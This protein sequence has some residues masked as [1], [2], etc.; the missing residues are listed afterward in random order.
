MNGLRLLTSA[1][2]VATLL[3]CEQ[4]P[5][6]TT[7]DTINEAGFF[8]KFSPSAGEI[9][10]PNNLL[11]SGSVDGTL[12]IP[13]TSLTG[14]ELAVATALNSMDGFSTVA[15]ISAGFSS[16]IDSATLVAGT[17]VR[18]F[19]VTITGPIVTSIDAELSASDFSVSLSTVDGADVT[20]PDLG[21]NKLVIT[22][23]KP[24]KP[25][26][27]YVALLTNGIK[28][29]QGNNAAADTIY[30]FTKS[31][32]TLTTTS[33]VAATSLAEVKYSALLS[34]ADTDGNGTI[35]AGA[36]T[37]AALFSVNSL[38]GLRQVTN[39]TEA[40][41]VASASPAITSA[42]II[43][44][45][46]FNTQ[47]T[48]IS[49]GGSV[50]TDARANVPADPAH[51]INS[52]ATTTTTIVGG[53]GYADIHVGTIDVPYYQAA[54]DDAELS[55]AGPAQGYWENSDGA[56]SF[57]T[58]A[59]RIPVA[60]STQ[61]IPLLL[62]IPNATAPACVG[63]VVGCKGAGWPVV[64]F[65]HGIT[66]DR[67]SLLA[68]ADSLA[69]RGIAAVAIDMPLHGLFANDVAG[70]HAA[71]AGL[72]NATER[73]FEVDYVDNETGLPP[74]GDGAD[75]SGANFV[76]LSYLMTTRGNLNQAIADLFVVKQSLL[77]SGTGTGMDYSG[78]TNGDFDPA[79]IY[80][81]GHSLGA[82]VGA[83]F[84]AIES[85]NMGTDIKDAV[86]AMPGGGIAKLL[87]GSSTFGPVISAGLAA[88]GV[89]KGTAEFE[90]FL[91]ASQMM[92]DEGDPINYATTLAASLEGILM[93]EVVGDGVDN[94][95]DLVIPNSVADANDTTGTVPAV[96]SGTEPLITLMNLDH[97]N[98]D[99]STA[100]L[101]AV[102]KYT[103]GDHGSL[104]DPTASA[105]ATTEMQTQ[106]AQFLIIDGGF[107]DVTDDAVLEAPPAP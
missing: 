65:Q 27:S 107:L 86:L 49:P 74:G 3:G 41:I 30:A 28:G 19:E 77:N 21:A 47:S 50:L 80:F 100:N 15:P 51:N 43:L 39:V 90:S 78:D 33:P 36:E 55:I 60:Q 88:N 17:T 18:V 105:A 101:H 40:T 45:W 56:G 106:A 35:D 2:I 24:L 76:N 93:F 34:T 9:P 75:T 62:S 44:S 11:F 84:V 31:T 12:N 14:G 63:D 32:A 95:S 25:S 72:P 58:P 68:I 102:V 99:T 69:A 46:S 29:L 5:D 89:T 4:T 8:A 81:V 37:T 98:V 70:I 91:S 53:A 67:T 59:N 52:T 38:E 92:V 7:Q 79:K 64:I 66:A 20:D 23:L 85:T 83:T 1:A 87:D 6:T 71:T 48:A 61:T 13:T 42:E 104:L 16:A 82:M 73:H 97:L 94:V 96:L 103:E 54:D 10:F 22:P 26:T 57:T